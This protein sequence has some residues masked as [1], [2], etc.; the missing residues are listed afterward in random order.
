MAEHPESEPLADYLG[1]LL[2][3]AVAETRPDVI[4]AD[5]L[6]QSTPAAKDYESDDGYVVVRVH[7]GD[8]PEGPHV[9]A[10]V[11]VASNVD[12]R[13][14]AENVALVAAEEVHSIYIGVA[15]L[16]IIVPSVPGNLLPGMSEFSSEAVARS[17]F[18]PLA[19]EAGRELSVLWSAIR[20]PS[21]EWPDPAGYPDAEGYADC[22]LGPVKVRVFFDLFEGVPRYRVAM[23]MGEA[24]PA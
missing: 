9:S 20:S 12:R 5:E 14:T 10:Q 3:N 21:F 23:V 4:A 24:A 16:G 19:K 15:A 7:Y 2:A 22:E 6:G 11:L 18:Y 13:S 17:E 1:P 8:S